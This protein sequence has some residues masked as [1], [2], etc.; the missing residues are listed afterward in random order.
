[1]PLSFG[2]D[3]GSVALKAMAVRDERPAA[4]FEEPTQPTIT[5]QA[6]AAL[7]RLRG[8]CA[9]QQAETA[10]LC[11][12]GYGRN[13]VDGADLRLSEILANAVGVGWLQRHWEDLQETFGAA[14]V[15][16]RLPQRVRTIVDVGGQD[17]KVIVI[18]E[19]GLIRDFAM[20]DRCA[21][22]TG[23][24]LEVMARV[25]KVDL[26]ELDHMALRATEPA[27]ITSA[28]T[29]FAESEVVSLLAEGAAPEQV[30]AGVFESIADQVAAL[31]GRSGWQAPV[32]FDGGTSRS[33]A[34]RA[35]LGRRF[36]CE[37]AIPPAGQFATALGAAVFAARGPATGR[38]PGPFAAVWGA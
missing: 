8:M 4:W 22:G 3:V 21:A 34:L 16:E 9:P 17:S 11:A 30:A 15:P 10:R 26:Q 31:A 28:C 18:D 37:V 6:V 19:D 5:P 25:L 20:N 38:Q 33:L 7:E 27:R 36:A 14:P 2:I 35:A 24:F 23:R 1:M 12:T 29:V 32:L 13:L